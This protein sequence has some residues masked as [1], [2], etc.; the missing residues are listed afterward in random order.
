MSRLG[1]TRLQRP[2]HWERH[3]GQIRSQRERSRHIQTVP[4]PARSHQAELPSNGAP[5]RGELFIP[6]QRLLMIG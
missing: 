3:S 6:G 4:D 5:D 1:P 2:E